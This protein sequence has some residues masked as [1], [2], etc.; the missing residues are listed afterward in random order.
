MSNSAMP[1]ALAPTNSAYRPPFF[2]ALFA[3]RQM[4][5]PGV[6]LNGRQGMARTDCRLVLKFDPVT[7]AL[8]LSSS[9]GGARTSG[10]ASGSL[11]GI[12]LPAN[13]AQAPDCALLLIDGNLCLKR[14]MPALSFQAV[15]CYGGKGKGSRQ[16]N[17]ASAI[18]ICSGNF[19]SATRSITAWWCFRFTAS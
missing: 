7:A 8:A 6:S 3:S 1:N 5:Q 12:R 4:I 17:G 11:G 18:A 13:M 10:E 16:F 15:P 9:P 19:S 2:G 14:L